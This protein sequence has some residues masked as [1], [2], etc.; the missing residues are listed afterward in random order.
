M[1]SWYIKSKC[2]FIRQLC[3]DIANAKTEEQ[4]DKSVGLVIES[5]IKIE[6]D[7]INKAAAQAF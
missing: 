7:L 6:N 4:F 5:T 3:D 2:E 1:E